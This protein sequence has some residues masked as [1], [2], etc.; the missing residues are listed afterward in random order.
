ME[1]L[2]EEEENERKV[3]NNTKEERLQA[4]MRLKDIWKEKQ[5][6]EEKE[7]SEP[8]MT[9]AEE[10]ARL[11][12]ELEEAEL[13]T[14]GEYLPE[15]RELCLNCVM[16]PCMCVMLYLDLKLDCL[17]EKRKRRILNL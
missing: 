11:V 15:S 1:K 4:V 10:E 13:M 7:E 5:K 8:D 17:R 3:R 6:V 14:S 9:E 12:E 2:R 16:S